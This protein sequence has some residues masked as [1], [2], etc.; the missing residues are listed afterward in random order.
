MQQ[1]LNAEQGA[2]ITRQLGGSPYWL[3]DPNG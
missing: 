2:Q 1:E 3:K